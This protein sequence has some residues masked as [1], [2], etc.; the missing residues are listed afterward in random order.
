MGSSTFACAFASGFAV[1]ISFSSKGGESVVRS[2]VFAAAFV[3]AFGDFFSTFSVG[4]FFA[5]CS[6]LCAFDGALL[7]GLQAFFSALTV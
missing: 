7:V 3:L 4:L 2:P 5:G 1:G 6:F